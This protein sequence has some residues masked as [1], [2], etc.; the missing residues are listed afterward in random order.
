MLKRCKDKISFHRFSEKFFLNFKEHYCIICMFAIV[1]A[2]LIRCVTPQTALFDERIQI[3]DE[4]IQ[5]F[6]ECIKLF[7]ERFQICDE[8]IIFLTNVPKNLT[9]VA[10]IYPPSGQPHQ[11]LSRT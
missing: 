9:V 1:Y 10:T 8:R 7:D 11:N 2:R 5:I 3:G 4:R 6:D